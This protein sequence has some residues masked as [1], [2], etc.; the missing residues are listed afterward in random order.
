MKNFKRHGRLGGF[1]TLE[2]CPGRGLW[3]PGLFYF[4]CQVKRVGS[5]MHCSLTTGS[6][7]KKHGQMMGWN[8]R[9]YGPKWIFA[10]HE[11]S[12]HKVA[13]V[14][15]NT[16]SRCPRN[17]VVGPK[18]ANL[19]SCPQGSALAVLMSSDPLFHIQYDI[20]RQQSLVFSILLQV[21][22]RDTGDGCRSLVHK[23]FP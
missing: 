17:S 7:K 13:S 21:I 3:D 16:H 19:P 11:I 9:D 5:T 18:L 8:T 23:L 20:I 6:K 12:F 2:T 15:E 14:I 10:L 4:L 22:L 1:R